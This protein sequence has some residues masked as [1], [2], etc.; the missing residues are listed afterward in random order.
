MS[1]RV[2][3]YGAGGH[4]LVVADILALAG[5]YEIAGFIDDMAPERRGESFGP[6]RILGT[7]AALEQ[8]L[9]QGIRHAIVAIGDCGARLRIADGLV[10]TGF[11]LVCA[12]HPSATVA[13]DV[14]IG[15]GSVIC[16]QAVINPC[17]TIGA[18]SIINTA[19]SVDHHC[20][21]GAG[22]HVAPGARLGGGVRVGR[23]AWV[24]IGATLIERVTI[25]ERA[26]VGA[27]A[28][29]LRDVPAAMLAYGVPARPI[30]SIER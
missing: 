21:I 27:G 12:I 20:E 8:A 3:V 9:E 22:A 4:A 30:R 17:A 28:L 14:Q 25:G 11:D 10:Q 24:G 2:I 15:P 16:A 18:N 1:A 13:G 5:R 26:I 23:G 19:A 6:A 29:V 7:A